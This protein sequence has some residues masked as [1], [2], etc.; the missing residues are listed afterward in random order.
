MGRNESTFT[1]NNTTIKNRKQDNATSNGTKK[2]GVIT[3]AGNAPRLQAPND[4]RVPGYLRK[5]IE[6]VDAPDNAD[7]DFL[8]KLGE[9][10]LAAKVAEV[11]D[12]NLTIKTGKKRIPDR[13]AFDETAVLM[14]SLYTFRNIQ[15]TNRIVDVLLS[16]YDAKEGIYVANENQLYEKMERISPDFKK[17]DME[18]VLD[19]IKRSVSSVEQTQERHLYA[20]KNGVYDK[21]TGTLELFKPE[22]V[23][24]AKIQVDYVENPINPVITAPDG[25]KWDVDSWINDTMDYDQDTRMLIWQVI[26]DCIQPHHSRH[27]SIW[28]YSEKGNN[29][30]GTIGQLIKNILGKGNYASLSVMDFKHEYLKSTLLGVAAN[31]CDENDVD[32]YVDAVKDFKASITEDD[33]NINQKYEHPLRVQLRI[34]N[35]QMMNG[36]PKTKDKSDSFYR[37]IILV[38]FMKSFTNNGERKY[39]KN[40][41]I[42]QQGVLEYVL[43]K[44]LHLDFDE[45]IIPAASAALMETYK[46]SNDPVMEYWNELHEE[47]VW[48]FLPTTFLFDV[49]VKWYK[50]ANP[51]GNPISRIKFIGRLRNV[52][53]SQSNAWSDMTKDSTRILQRMDADEPLITRYGLD[54]RDKNGTESQW[55]NGTYIGNNSQMQRDFTRSVKYRGFARI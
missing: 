54:R 48:D 35:I 12:Y 41:F 50:S 40:D 42:K 17:K 5:Y 10:A 3:L 24:L 49:F 38:P 1:D 14:M 52:I 33:I 51:S 18:D 32:V 23:F 29:G 53:L 2:T 30:K 34:T 37:R 47:F 45:F 25:F 39:I 6:K 26:A 55:M 16:M 43:H 20:F 31:I 36:L 4:I 9:G 13:L 22:Y 28:F 27:K 15:M 11:E 44:A 19:K 7:N 21:K 8:I 46:E